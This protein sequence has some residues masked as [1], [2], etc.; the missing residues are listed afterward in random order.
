[1]KL[2]GLYR[3]IVSENIP[4]SVAIEVTTSCNQKCVHCYNDKRKT[5]TLSLDKIK[6]IL[7]EASELGSLFLTITGGEPMM[8]EDIWDIL[9]YS[10]QSNFATLLFTNGTLIGATEAARLKRIGVYWVD[11]TLLGA[12]SETHDRLT[13]ISGS[14]ESVM[15]AI[16]LL[17]K[18]EIGISIKTPVLTENFSELGRIR[19][20]VSEMKLLHIFSPVIYPRDNGNKEPVKHRLTNEQMTEYLKHYE[21][22]LKINPTGSFSCDLG[23]V[24]FAVSARGD[25]YP[26][27]NVPYKLGNISDISINSLWENSSALK[28]IREDSEKPCYSFSKCNKKFWCFRCEGLAL[29]ERK[30]MF[31]SDSESCRMAELRKKIDVDKKGRTDQDEME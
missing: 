5:E 22:A 12:T 7:D 11:I 24:M 15:D 13:G 20:M 3:K 16:R 10:V 9:D 18:E 19:E 29:L 26:C 23:K 8:R 4:F 28:K 1:M 27:L 2:G 6:R 25:V 30:K 17:K 21:K 31:V 14:F